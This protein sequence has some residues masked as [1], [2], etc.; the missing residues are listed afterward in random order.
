MNQPLVVSMAEYSSARAGAAR[1]QRG[2]G[3]N[4]PGPG[5]ADR[6]VGVGGPIATTKF[7][8]AGDG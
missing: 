5:S 6:A 2:G 8:L 7:M 3:M 4:E 1:G